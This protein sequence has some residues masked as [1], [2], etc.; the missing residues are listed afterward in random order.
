MVR[1]TRETRKRHIGVQPSATFSAGRCDASTRS[2]CLVEFEPRIR[3]GISLTL[4][5]KVRSMYGDSIR[6]LAQE[7]CTT[8]DVKHA[9]IRIHDQGALPFVLAARI[10]AAIKRALPQIRAPYLPG[11]DPKHKPATH[12]ADARRTRLYLPGNEPK[13]FINAGLHRPD[14]VVLDLE[15]SV[16]PAEKDTARILVRNAL[17]SV[18]FHGAERG[19][20]IN[21]GALGLDDLDAV[22]PQRP[23]LVLI[24]KCEGR[25]AVVEVEN[26]IRAIEGE[27]ATRQ[28]ILLLPII[29]SALGVVNAYSIASASARVCALAI[30]LEDYTADLGVERTSGGRESFF[31]RMAVV[32]AA[33]AAGVQALDSVYSDVDDMEGLRT[34]TLEAKSLG[35]EGKGCIHPRQ[36]SVIH[37]ALAPTAEEVEKARRIVEAAE[38]ALKAGCGVVALGSKMID[39]P[40]VIRA[41]RVLKL[42]ERCERDQS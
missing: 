33:K 34:S 32:N 2:D 30:G 10:E 36:V 9:A 3:G 21:Q 28:I 25:L 24:P 35:F 29:E 13:F 16:A 27:G 22:I 8:L 31:A 39:A 5:S 40:V 41:R 11:P 6:Q 18:D 12:P 20:R 1:A 7:V 26:A 42:A 14:T 37:S 38:E 15:D 19:V 17:R 23:D 4:E